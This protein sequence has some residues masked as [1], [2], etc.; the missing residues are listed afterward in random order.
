MS[1]GDVCGLC[2]RSGAPS[3]RKGR[4]VRYGQRTAPL[5]LLTEENHPTH[6]KRRNRP[7]WQEKR[8]RSIICC[9]PA[10]LHVP[11][12]YG[13]QVRSAPARLH[14]RRRRRRR[15]S[16]AFVIVAGRRRRQTP[17]GSFP[18]DTRGFPPRLQPHYFDPCD[19]ASGDDGSG[20]HRAVE[21]E[22]RKIPEC[23]PSLS[24]VLLCLSL[25]RLVPCLFLPF[26]SLRFGVTERV[27]YP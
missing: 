26:R 10:G 12:A 17:S 19:A 24:L 6:R 7:E 20:D 22:A 16:L 3:L 8:K 21:W 4:P 15:S 18:A 2:P 25:L 1:A 5:S 11:A 14:R 13:A 9:P 27:S 23:S